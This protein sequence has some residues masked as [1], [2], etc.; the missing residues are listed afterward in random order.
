MANLVKSVKDKYGDTAE[1]FEDFGTVFL[2]VRDSVTSEEGYGEVA[3]SPKKARK[4]ANAL[5]AA[6][7]AADGK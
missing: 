1:V 7:A 3:F 6:A 2:E 4:L 5:L